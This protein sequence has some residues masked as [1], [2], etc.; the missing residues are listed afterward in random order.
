MVPDVWD[1]TLEVFIP[2]ERLYPNTRR[3]Q[4]QQ[5]AR[6]KSTQRNAGSVGPVTPGGGRVEGQTC[7]GSTHTLG[8][9]YSDNIGSATFSCVGT[10]VVNS[11]DGTERCAW[12]VRPGLAT[13]VNACPTC[14]PTDAPRTGCN[15]GTPTPG[16]I[17]SPVTPVIP[18]NPSASPVCPS[19]V[20]ARCNGRMSWLL[21]ELAATGGTC[22]TPCC[23][24]ILAS[25]LGL[26]GRP[27]TT[28][29]ACVAP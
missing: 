3:Y 22:R 26:P 10:Q 27:P 16:P 1:A 25:L 18:V 9:G 2:S 29:I 12:F 11:V 20:A 28:R 24:A 13:P 6:K 7:T 5:Y 14:V 23:R 19:V 8:A 15:N 4:Q 17:P 21:G